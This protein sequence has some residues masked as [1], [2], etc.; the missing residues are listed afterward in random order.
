MP[1]VICISQVKI[2]P[3]K[4]RNARYSFV[5]TVQEALKGGDI[6]KNCSPEGQAMRVMVPPDHLSQV[7]HKL[8][9]VAGL[10]VVEPGEDIAAGTPRDSH[11]VGRGVAEGLKDA[12]APVARGQ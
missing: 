2:L 11:P 9:L 4:V 6:L 8:V 5:L 7:V 12:C 3:L 1:H 10:Q